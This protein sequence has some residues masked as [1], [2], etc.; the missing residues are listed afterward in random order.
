MPDWL[1]TLLDAQQL[2]IG[3]I[4]LAV[5]YFRGRHNERRHLAELTQ[6]EHKV[7]DVLVFATRYPPASAKPLDPI[8]VTGSARQPLPATISR[9]SWPGCE[10]SLVAVL[11][12]TS[13]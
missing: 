2:V 13:T 11:T 8:V 3:A 1:K 4:L 5:G 12:P 10:K 9:C 7:R 6:Q